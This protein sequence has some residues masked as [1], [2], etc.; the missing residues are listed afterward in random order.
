MEVLI[1]FLLVMNIENMP[2]GGGAAFVDNFESVE[3]CEVAAEKIEKSYKRLIG[4]RNN[5]FFMH[6]C[7]E[8]RKT[9]GEH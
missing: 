7:I 3:L 4:R 5:F 1:S 6:D 8:V 2:H 9:T